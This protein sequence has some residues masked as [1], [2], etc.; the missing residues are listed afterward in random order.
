MCRRGKKHR[1]EARPIEGPLG[2]SPGGPNCATLADE[3][4]PRKE[5]STQPR[6]P[7]GIFVWSELRPGALFPAAPFTVQLRQRDPNPAASAR[8]AGFR[9]KAR[10]L[11]MHRSCWRRRPTAHW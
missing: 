4:S 2:S 3:P 1:R 5:K 10:M 9:V 11:L 7:A 8:P 6:R